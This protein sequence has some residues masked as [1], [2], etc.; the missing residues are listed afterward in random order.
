[1]QVVALVP[2]GRAGAAAEHGGD[3]AAQRLLDLLRADEVDVAVDA[4]GGDDPALAGDGL[5]A[6]ADDDVDA[7]L[8]VRVAGLA[9][10][11]DAAVAD[12]DVGLD[13]AP[14]VE[15]ERVGDDG[16]DGARGAGRLRLA[17]AVADHLAA[18]EL[19]LLA[20]DGAVLLDL[21]EELGVG[22]PHAVAGGRPEHVGI[23]A[24][25]MIVAA[26]ACPPSRR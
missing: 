2:V 11:G 23:G 25:G 20:V 10:A 7:R 16:V 5:G 19:D 22:Q 8:D 6:R 14:V 18:A 3:A 1:M 21:D 12:A 24:R 4:A 15:D 26:S 9:D 17:H 13:D